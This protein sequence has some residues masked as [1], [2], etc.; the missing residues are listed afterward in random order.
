MFGYGS[1]L[2][3]SAVLVAAVAAGLAAAVADRSAAPERAQWALFLSAA[4]I[5][6]ALFG[7]LLLRQAPRRRAPAALPATLVLEPG[8]IVPW[9][10]VILDG[11]SEVDDGP[12]GGSPFA[13][14][15]RAGDRLLHGARNGDGRL[16][17]RPAPP[18]E[19]AA[20]GSGTGADS[21]YPPWVNRHARKILLGLLALAG[22]AAIRIDPATGLLVAAAA[23]PTC[24]GL[25]RPVVFAAA[26]T[27]ARRLGIELR[28]AAALDALAATDTVALAPG[29]ILTRLQLSLLSLHPAPEIKPAEVIGA[30]TTCC[31]SSQSST[32]RAILHFG[33]AH[34]V[35]LRKINA[36]HAEAAEAPAAGEA[37]VAVTD[38]GATLALAD[39]PWL[40]RQGLAASAFDAIELPVMAPGRSL[41]WIAETAPQLHLLGALVLGEKL[42]PGAAELAKNLK[43]LNV[44]TVLLDAGATDGQRALAR[45]LGLAQSLAPAAAGTAA[46]EGLLL[47]D[48]TGAAPLAGVSAARLRFGVAQ[49]HGAPHI[50]AEI[51]REDPR[52]ILDL[53][54]LARAARRRELYACWLAA[55]FC[56]PGLGY[57]LGPRVE[58]GVGIGVGLS[59]GVD[60][61][62]LSPLIGLAAVVLSAQFLHLFQPTASEVDEE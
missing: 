23:V 37:I 6:L 24:L 16:T 4:A 25:I 26:R 62:T 55:A 27:K 13:A 53:I 59:I 38:L 31:Q 12:V 34:A 20:G 50:D 22:A 52:L 11:T 5:L 46:G 9:D 40:E 54:R 35:R 15:R 41:V 58:V 36:W 57:A 45:Q 8:Q 42:K 49:V 10:A 29:G 43:R 47:V 33:V 18:A 1:K 28:D 48:R 60:I 2:G 56:L 61:A 17:I 14:R 51:R 30:A 39:R 7:R 21:Q 32:A 19:A 3:G 44:A